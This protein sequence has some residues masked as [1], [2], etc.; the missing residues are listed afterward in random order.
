MIATITPWPRAFLPPWHLFAIHNGSLAA[1]CHAGAAGDLI[2]QAVALLSDV[3]VLCWIEGTSLIEPAHKRQAC[4]LT[5]A[6]RHAFLLARLLLVLAARDAPL[7]SAPVTPG[8][9]GIDGR[10]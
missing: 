6:E 8:G 3:A 7:T 5:C 9:R 1:N 10:H 2:V 4:Q